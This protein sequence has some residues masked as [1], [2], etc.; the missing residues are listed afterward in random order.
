[1]IMAMLLTACG[2]GAAS[3]AQIKEVRD[4]LNG[5]TS[6]SDGDKANADESEKKDD[7]VFRTEEMKEGAWDGT[8]KEDK[9]AGSE[10]TVTFLLRDVWDGGFTANVTI[11]NTGK[12][13][14]KDWELKF[15]YGGRISN[16][17]NVKATK[18]GDSEYTITT[19]EDWNRNIEPGKK[20][21]FGMS[22]QTDFAGFPTDYQLTATAAETDGTSSTEAPAASS[23]PGTDPN[24]SADPNATADPGTEEEVDVSGETVSGTVKKHGRLK[25]KG[26]YI[27]DK[28]GKKFL[29]KGPSTHGIAWFPDYVNKSAF[30]TCK[31][32]GANTVRLACYSSE[33]E[34]YNTGSV[35][36]T[37]DKG[38]KAATELG[39]YVIID[40]HILNENKPMMSFDRAKTFFTRFAKKYGKRKNVIWEICNEPNG[41]EWAADIKPYAKKMIPLI[42]KYSKNIIVVGTPTWSQDVDVVANDRLTGRYKKDVCYTFH[43]YAATHKDDLRNRVKTA[44]SKG[45]PILCT[46]FSIC[47]ASGAGTLDKASGNAWINLFRK[48]S[49][50]YI[51][52]SLCNKDEAASLLL[53]TCQKTGNFKKS[54]LSETGKWVVSKWK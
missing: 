5:E 20:V 23:E 47:E 13:L 17:W 38:V 7:I 8:T 36:N 16:V 54:D 51:S 1:M 52:W 43:F 22:E 24:A 29:I 31:K 32:W 50:G 28:K 11:E 6:S 10:Y 26:R 48:N 3:D 53:P 15:K 41:C 14:L 39:M 21:E 42:R 37:I 4:V 30:K 27:V 35:W 19:T 34:G 44:I 33:G 25:V 12:K 49:I 9:Y 45:L 2:S 46:E 18:T 40:W